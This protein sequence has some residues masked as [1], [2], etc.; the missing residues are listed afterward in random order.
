VEGSLP[1]SGR[2]DVVA[3]DQVFGGVPV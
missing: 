3:P 2:P 1:V